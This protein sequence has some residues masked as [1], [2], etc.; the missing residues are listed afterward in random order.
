MAR[1][2]RIVVPGQ[3]L[4]IIQR[5]NNRQP[6]F[7]A[8]D[9][10]HFY[11]ASLK[12]AADRFGCRIHA[13]VLMTNHVHLLL[14][15]D[16]VKAP[17]LTLQS[18]GR[19]YVRYVNTVYQRSGTL[20]EGRYKSTLIDSERYLLTCSRYIEL[21]PLRARMVEDPGAYRWSSYR[22]NADGFPDALVLLHPLYER[23]GDD[24]ASR[25]AAYRALF[26]TPVDDRELDTIRDAT[27]T[28][29]V[30]GHDRFRGEIENALQR[31]L[32]R[33]PHGGDRKSERFRERCRDLTR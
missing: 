5:G 3:P 22:F 19:H 31:R 16:S 6:C 23:L 13:Y 28:G 25:R 1:W 18:V 11:L 2:P 30:L 33:Q 8:D 17:S 20:W 32:H 15:P 4:H 7:F 29:T 26:S 14:T 27:Q 24:P 21:N 9:D 12:D 10:Y